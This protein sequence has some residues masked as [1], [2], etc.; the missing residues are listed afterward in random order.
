[1]F[2]AILVAIISTE[3]YCR[4]SAAH[5][6]IKMPD[7]VPLMVAQSF[8]AI[9]P[10]AAPL[11][12]FNLI[13]YG[14]T[15]TSYG[16]AI[17]F[18]YQILQQPL[19]GLGGTLP[20]VLIAV[21]FTQFFWWF[22]IHGTLLVNSIIDPIM[23]SL[24]LQN[25]DAYKNGAEHLPHII[26]TTFMGVFVNQ[27][28]Q[29]GIAIM[30]AFFLA[31]SVRMKQTMRLVFAPAIFNVSEPMTY[32]L[33]VVLNPT[34][35]IPWILAPLASTTISYFTIAAGLVPRPT[36]ATVV[37]TTPIFVA[38]WLGTGSIRGG[39]LQLV[40]VVVMT[41]IWIPFIKALDNRWYK[42]EQNPD[43]DAAEKDSL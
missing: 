21:F 42:D 39:I 24:A 16:N 12:L 33:P 17:D 14:F 34:L 40:D 4:I 36:G 1:M 31:R 37:W 15:F 20:A 28:M 32:G 10:G 30:F 6:V 22:G 2:V 35:F 7:S 18:V 5:I 23:S 25:Y 3:L 11:F 9:I 41:L 38:G 27:G 13:R 8:V 26:S 19:M 29:L 43:L